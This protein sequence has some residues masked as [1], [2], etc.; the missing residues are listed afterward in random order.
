VRNVHFINYH[1]SELLDRQGREELESIS[2]DPSSSDIAASSDIKPL[3]SVQEKQKIR[4]Q[5]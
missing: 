2:E 1:L 5:I 4:R 3:V